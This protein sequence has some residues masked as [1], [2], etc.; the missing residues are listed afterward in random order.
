M[1]LS[2]LA[3]ASIPHHFWHFD[4]ETMLFLIIRLPFPVF[5]D[6]SPFEVLFKTVPSYKFLKVFGCATYSFIR[7]HNKHKLHI[8]LFIVYF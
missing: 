4:F 3:H 8:I 2:L 1:G 7:P 5:R 6:K